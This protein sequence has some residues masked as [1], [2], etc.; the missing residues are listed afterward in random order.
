[1]IPQPTQTFEL[2]PAT[3]HQER[4]WLAEAKEPG[5][6]IYNVWCAFRVKGHL[7]PDSWTAA[8]NDLQ[9]RHEPLRTSFIMIDGQL[10]QC[11]RD[12]PVPLDVRV[13]L[14]CADPDSQAVEFAQL[15][16]DLEKGPLWR[17][18]LLATDSFSDESL[19]I[20][21]LHHIAVDGESLR[22]LL[23]DL[24]AACRARHEGKEPD[25][26]PLDLQ[27]ADFADWLSRENQTPDVDWWTDQL[28]DHSPAPALPLDALRT[29]PCSPSAL[30]RRF[31]LTDTVTDGL[32]RIA[33]AVHTSVTTVMLAAWCLLLAHHSDRR[34]LLLGVPAAGRS[35]PG[36]TEM[37]GV[38]INTLPVRLHVPEGSFASLVHHC[39]D[40]LADA[41]DH[42][43]TPL[44]SII[45]ALKVQRDPA[46]T[47]L[48]DTLF[49]A[50]N[51]TGVH[52][53]LPEATVTWHD[54]PLWLTRHDLEL[55]VWDDV[56]AHG[57]LVLRDGLFTPA[58]AEALVA[59]Y[60]Q[61]LAG[62]AAGEDRIDSLDQSLPPLPPTPIHGEALEVTS[63]LLRSPGVVDARTVPTSDPEKRLVSFVVCQSRP[64]E[65][66]LREGLGELN[67]RVAAV[68]PVASLPMLNSGRLDISAL[69]AI[70]VLDTLTLD[71]WSHNVSSPS[72]RWRMGDLPSPPRPRVPHPGLPTSPRTTET[73]PDQDQ[74]AL[75]PSILDGG[76]ALPLPAH[77][78][79][80]CLVMNASRGV[81]ITLIDSRGAASR[82]PCS[83]LENQARRIAA[84]LSSAGL[85]PGQPLVIVFEE[86]RDLLPALWAGFLTGHPIVV[87][88]PSTSQIGISE[89]CSQ[90]F[91]A[92]GPHTLLLAPG[93]E[94]RLDRS[95]LQVPV[96][97]ILDLL[98]HQPSPLTATQGPEDIALL[99]LTSGSTGIPKAVQLTHRMIL[100][101]S[102]AY[103]RLAGLGEQDRSL[104]WMP[105]DH[106][107]GVVM[108][109]LRDI[110][111][112]AEQVHAATS[113]VLAD[114]LRW[115]Q[116][117]DEY[118]ITNTW[119]PNFAE[120]LVA[121]EA[122]R[123][124]PGQWDLSC[125]RHV[126]NGGEA[127]LSDTVRRFVDALAPQG[128]SRD[129]VR[130]SWGMS[131][132]SSGETDAPPSDPASW[133]DP[134]PLGPPVPGFRMR[135]VDGEGRPTPMGTTGA[136][137]VQGPSVTP[138]YWINPTANAT[139]FTS[140]GWFRTGD[141]AA[142]HEGQLHIV[143]R[144][145]EEVI[146]NGVNIS[147]ELVEQ[148]VED[149]C[150]VL[151]AN[152]VAVGM[153]VGDSEQL[154][155]VAV[156]AP[157]ADPQL[158]ITQLRSVIQADIG[159]PAHVALV[160]SGQVPRTNIGKRQRLLMRDRILS[161]E[162]VPLADSGLHTTGD[163][164]GYF[165]TVSWRLQERSPGTVHSRLQVAGRNIPDWLLAAAERTTHT[166]DTA[167]GSIAVLYLTPERHARARSAA[168]EAIDLAHEVRQWFLGH[169]ASHGHLVVVVNGSP[170]NSNSA[171][172]VL[173]GL[174][175]TLA[176]EHDTARLRLI[177][178]DMTDPDEVIAEILSNDP[179]DQVWLRQQRRL[180]CRLSH[181]HPAK[182]GRSA[183]TDGAG[184]LVITGGTSQ[185]VAEL[186]DWLD[187]RPGPIA[188]IGRRPADRVTAWWPDRR[189]Y[190][191]A[192]VTDPEELAAA[193]EEL[194][195]IAGCPV[196]SVFHVA[197]DYQEHDFGDPGADLGPAM[198][199]KV[200][201]AGT[202]LDVT[203]G[204]PEVEITLGSSVSGFIGSPGACGY[205]AANSHL[206]SL[207]EL[208]HVRT[209]AWS[210]WLETGMSRGY[211]RQER[212]ADRGST[213]LEPRQ[214][215][216]MTRVALGTTHPM[217][218]I[219]LDDTRPWVRARTWP[220]TGLAV[221]RVETISS[222]PDHADPGCLDVLGRPVATVVA[223]ATTPEEDLAPRPGMEAVVND[224]W[225]KVL[226]IT[227]IGRNSSFFDVGGTSI[228]LSR[229][230]GLLEEELGR[231]IR[232]IDL[233][234]HH[235][236]S[237]MA[238]HLDSTA[239]AQDTSTTDDAA[240][241]GQRRAQARR[242]RG[243]RR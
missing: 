30:A 80:D 23:T 121:D 25:W 74:P 151:A 154:L 238:R 79:W 186:R 232:L 161:G 214:A 52:L 199:S 45:Q 20:I 12:A 127:V 14:N 230:Q 77:Q 119:S 64:D 133:M 91:E 51:T 206:N 42:Q 59:S 99:L 175:R 152:T 105:L 223:T 166:L 211:Q 24:T 63:R 215:S 29:A 143:G 141:R 138:G 85:P 55:N 222:S 156:P 191:K 116:L 95:S 41:Y 225:S 87:W 120:G 37:V 185:V 240:Q 195:G 137:E 40:V 205:A 241:R 203:A 21:S 169:V 144:A 65:L 128:L 92:L 204:L 180:A 136:L 111:L 179:T 7:D 236:V 233:F 149:R 22:I 210:M 97:D 47:P 200:V 82:L 183:L 189:L 94:E 239:P 15:P 226:G 123:L 115:M 4:M 197:G 8:C 164:P 171:A 229:V 157:G 153:P 44:E 106:V 88:N 108:F 188:V 93:L 208:A 243:V 2:Y 235:T 110:V 32:R 124:L 242:Q 220:D 33:R 150:E 135:V 35:H 89:R 112:G 224:I 98:H 192:D 3:P 148:L 122:H 43:D 130:P 165:H 182:H 5:S 129:A 163:L 102:V 71:H 176:Q 62:I 174:I 168:L 36:T 170:R 219:G 78:L 158:L 237:A 69:G 114:P 1:M 184:L 6:P 28:R 53:Q 173:P 118:R 194:V 58:T 67:H 13:D 57:L 16:F 86:N 101:R 46:R 61:L 177:H 60:C 68:V 190:R 162:V 207:A 198:W 34:D 212:T 73:S 196:D 26:P 132:T 84:G 228:Q 10:H 75:P 109:H 70:P 231:S 56:R 216:A 19:L 217:V 39:R 202:I 66:R 227:R 147:C 126:L 146:V 193:L 159:L 100:H 96:L 48:F 31:E 38:F 11:I 178:Q 134:V 54:I 104:N 107:G 83:E 167:V 27:Y 221:R 76:P 139:S 9:T 142:F 18:A 17:S 113:W 218:L 209:I 187:N 81:G 103:S 117:V 131:E 234:K 155:V 125:L 201:G 90:L 49:T 140:D 160:A 50:Q 172:G 72:T 213:V 145:K 181:L